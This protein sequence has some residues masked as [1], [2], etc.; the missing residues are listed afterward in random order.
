MKFKHLMVILVTCLITIQASKQANAMSLTIPQGDGSYQI[1]HHEPIGQSFLATD[2]DIGS[3]SFYVDEMNQ[4]FAP[5]DYE[6]EFTL[7]EGAGNGGTLLTTTSNGTLTDGFEGWLSFDVSTIAFTG[8]TTYS[9]FI[10]NDTVRWSIMD[11]A[12]PYAGGMAFLSN[13][14]VEDWALQI[15]PGNTAAR[16]VPEPATLSLLGIGLVGLIGGAA[17]KKFKKKAIAKT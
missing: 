16:P 15:L 14:E 4:S 13:N 5:T 17:R 2:G 7:Y 9:A 3:I 1:D 6:L 8:G 10:W 12:S 11:A